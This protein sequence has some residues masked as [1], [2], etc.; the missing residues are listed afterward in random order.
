MAKTKTISFPPES[1]DLYNWLMAQPNHSE[2]V[3]QG[4]QL[5]RDKLAGEPTAND[6]AALS[7]QLTD[8]RRAIE[9]LRASGV[10]VERQVEEDQGAV[11]E[12]L[13]KFG[14]RE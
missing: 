1:D 6:V 9:D 13:R 2:A 4:L 3:R 8:I 11:E 12:L 10:I 7:V 5:L 14:K